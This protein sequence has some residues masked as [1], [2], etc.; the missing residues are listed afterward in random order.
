VEPSAVRIFLANLEM[1]SIFFF[2]SAQ[3][4]AVA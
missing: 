4:H 2:R 3:A 1:L